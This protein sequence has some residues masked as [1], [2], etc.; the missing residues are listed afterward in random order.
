[1]KVNQVPSTRNE[2][3]ER[4]EVLRNNEEEQSKPAA[5]GTRIPYDINPSQ[6]PTKTTLPNIKTFPYQNH[7]I[8][9]KQ[10]VAGQ[11]LNIPLMYNLVL[12]NN[13]LIK[14]TLQNSLHSFT[15]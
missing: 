6:S 11:P 1:M 10:R 3:E 8:I 9:T 7:E 12:W 5:E 13:F 14:I 4:T 2:E 15:S